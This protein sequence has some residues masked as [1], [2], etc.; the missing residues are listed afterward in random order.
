MNRIDLPALSLVGPTGTSPVSRPPSCTTPQQPTI[1]VVLYA[2][3]IF[4][5]CLIRNFMSAHAVNF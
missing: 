2:P 1:Y 3:Y 5:L 4:S